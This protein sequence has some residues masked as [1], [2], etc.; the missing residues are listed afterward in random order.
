V[1]F[2]L[3]ATVGDAAGVDAKQGALG[4]VVAALATAIAIGPAMVETFKT[5]WVEREP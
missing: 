2:A 4:G 5:A 1:H 3:A